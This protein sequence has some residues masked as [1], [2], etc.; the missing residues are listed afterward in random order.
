MSISKKIK[1][2]N[3]GMESYF[4]SKS[5]LSMTTN[6][7]PTNNLTLHLLCHTALQIK[8]IDSSHNRFTQ[9]HLHKEISSFQ[10]AIIHPLNKWLVI[11]SPLNLLL[12][13]FFNYYHNSSRIRNFFLRK[14]QVSWFRIKKLKIV[15]L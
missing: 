12:I 10:I 11:V 1:S 7:T 2:F 3:E 9:M 4:N 13:K 8:T 15:K 5:I 6:I 14:S